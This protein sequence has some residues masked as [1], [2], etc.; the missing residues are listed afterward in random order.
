MSS[1]GGALSLTLAT[2]ASNLADYYNGMLIEDITDS[3]T[4]T[5][6]DYSA[7]RVATLAAQ[8]GAASK[9][10]GI[11]SELPEEFHELIG[12]KALLLMKESHK[13]LKTPSK[14]EM[15]NFYMALNEKILSFF[16][17][18]DQDPVELFS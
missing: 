2:T 5:I 11:V 9:Y 16:G 12:P 3:W 4:D 10:Y 18:A 7:A 8:T 13:A 17:T 15:D 6:T 1:A 14:S